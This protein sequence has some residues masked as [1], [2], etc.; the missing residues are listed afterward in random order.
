MILQTTDYTWQYMAGEG[1][2]PSLDGCDAQVASVIT[3]IIA[4]IV[5]H[6]HWLAWYASEDC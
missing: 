3:V 5:E 6:R 1:V 2:H 4:I